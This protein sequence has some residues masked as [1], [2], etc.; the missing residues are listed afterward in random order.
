MEFFVWALVLVLM[1]FL[2]NL[3]DHFWVHKYLLVE[4]FQGL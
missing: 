2:D 4:I 1:L 3:L